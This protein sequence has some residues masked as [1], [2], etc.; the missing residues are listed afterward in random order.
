MGDVSLPSELGPAKPGCA[1]GCAFCCHTI[2]IVTAPEA[3][4]LAE[5]IAFDKSVDQQTSLAAAVTKFDAAV[6]GL[7]GD[8]RWGQGGPCPLL[9]TPENVCSVYN[10]RPLACRGLLSNSRR[11]CED[12]FSKR[13]ADPWTAGVRPFLFQ[14]SDVF[15]RALGA[16]LRAFGIDLYRL[17]LTAAVATIWRTE[18][19]FDRWLGGE[20]IFLNARA[21][22]ASWP[23]E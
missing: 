14:N 17:E 1:K 5:F 16:S 11:K 3:F 6:R 15:T 12:A 7:T 13:G 23:I 10:G 8:Q 22:N 18:G 21:P 20:D 9:A 2:V 19:A 4:Y